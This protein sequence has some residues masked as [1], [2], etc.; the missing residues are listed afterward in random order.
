[1]LD[2]SPVL[3]ADVDRGDAVRDS[4]AAQWEA[5]GVRELTGRRNGPPLVGPL[6]LLPTVQA[7]AARVASLSALLGD[8]VVVDGPDLLVER[9]RI[10]GH[11]RQGA[12]SVGGACR[13][14]QAADGWVAVSMARDE[15][16][17]AVPAWLEA[18]VDSADVLGVDAAIGERSVATLV[19]RA[20][21]LGIPC[22]GLGELL[23]GS[24]PAHQLNAEPPP[25][26]AGALAGLTVV[27]LSSLWAGPLCG[28]LLRA[29]GARVIKVESAARP[30]GARRGPAAFFDLMNGGKESVLLDLRT[31]AG[32]DDLSALVAGADVV[33]E[34]SRPRALEQLGIDAFAFPGRV[35]LSITAYGRQQP[36]RVGFGDD[37]AVGGGLVAWDEAGP[38]FVGDAVADPLT[39]LMGAAA[40][41]DRLV[42]GGRWLV[43]LGLAQA[44]ALA[45]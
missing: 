39:G 44:A 9:A 15:D 1:M 19:E 36:M 42:A 2:L 38:V 31:A 20:G 5:S 18:D 34:A 24:V 4:A 43:D 11:R 10:T 35:W 32:R 13:L 28:R 45:R 14:V 27:D 21:W 8:P 16:A 7:L 6:G 12:V 3:L 40:V 29:A 26:A 22:G 41:L 25:L 17:A 23:H 37:A 30:D 33:I